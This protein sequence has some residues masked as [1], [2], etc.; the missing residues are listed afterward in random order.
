ME[1]R[2]KE[3]QLCLFADRVSNHTM[4]ANQLR[5]WFATLAYILIN[6]LR[7]VGL[8]STSLA[9]ARA[10]TIRIKLLKIGTRV[11]VSVRRLFF[12]MASSHPW[13]RA[14]SQAFHQLQNTEPIPI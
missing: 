10:D 12:S 5:L 3:Q 6:H 8:K 13:Q 7:E 1:N 4:A 2:I 14:F 9:K 11:K